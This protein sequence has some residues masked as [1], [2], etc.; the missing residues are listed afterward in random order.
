[1]CVHSYVMFEWTTYRPVFDLANLV[2]SEV[3][4]YRYVTTD[5]VTYHNLLADVGEGKL[6]SPSELICPLQFQTR[7]QW[8]A[9]LGLV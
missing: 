4:V 5:R 3:A 6:A 2:A 1:M 9:S 7:F 8:T